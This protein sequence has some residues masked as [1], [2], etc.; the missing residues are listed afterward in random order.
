MNRL[1]GSAVAAVV[2]LSFTGCGKSEAE[3]VVS[4]GIRCLERAADILATIHDSTSARAAEPRLRE[5]L[6]ALGEQKLRAA[7]AP[8]LTPREMQHLQAQ[9]HAASVAA[10]KRFREQA[11][12]AAAI[13]GCHELVMDFSYQVV[14]LIK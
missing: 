10:N 8:A 5:V 6:S 12:R 1:T 4:D 9:N 3:K 11:D 13:P 2:L 14:R 7:K